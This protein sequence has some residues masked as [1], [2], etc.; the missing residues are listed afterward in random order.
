MDPRSKVGS[1]RRCPP[2]VVA[3]ESTIIS[4]GMPYPQN[5]ET[6]LAVEAIVRAGGAEPA[7]IAIIGGVPTVGLSPD[8]LDGLARTGSGA[9]KTSRRDLPLVVASRLTGATTVSATMLLAHAAGVR[10]F[11][12]G[13]VGGVHRGG[14]ATWDVSADLGELGRTPVAVVCAGVKSILDIPRTLEVLETQ[15]VPVLTWQSDEFPAFYTA[16]SGLRSPGRTDSAAHAAA[17]V[18]VAADFGL[19]GLLI[20]ARRRRPP[21]RPQRGGRMMRRQAAGTDCARPDGP[22]TDP[23]RTP[24]RRCPSRRRRR[25]TAQT[26]S[27]QRQLRWGRRRRRGWP[28]RR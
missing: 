6:A 5:L 19:G 3:L 13:G 27:A 8:Q 7:T 26:W 22:R 1:R 24:G 12:T 28:A 17:C 10:V 2:A 23:G 15:G 16:A 25:R 21:P 4:H 20:A 18:R 11:V 14:E 9:A